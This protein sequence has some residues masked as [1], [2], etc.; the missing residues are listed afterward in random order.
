MIDKGGSF[1]L[2]TTFKKPLGEQTSYEEP[3]PA[4]VRKPPKRVRTPPK[5][6]KPKRPPVPV[7]PPESRSPTP[8]PVS[9]SPSPPPPPPQKQ[10]PVE[11]VEEEHTP[12]I[13]VEELVVK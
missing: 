8:P 6:E 2:V 12:R 5:R 1:Q 13:Y 9:R 4:P 11:K 7:T 10:K 3:P